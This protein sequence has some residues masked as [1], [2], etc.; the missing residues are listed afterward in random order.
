MGKVIAVFDGCGTEYDENTL[1]QKGLGG[2]ETWIIYIAESL[3]KIPDTHVF[4]YC[5]CDYHPHYKY[6]NIEF[7]PHQYFI[8][9][10]LNYDAII[11]SRALSAGL[12]DKLKQSKCCDNIYL[13]GHDVSI[14]YLNENN[15]LEV[16]TYNHFLKDDFMKNNIKKIFVLSK[17]AKEYIISISNF[18][19]NMVELTHY[20]INDKLLNVNNIL[21]RDNNI[22]W[23]NC[24]ERNFNVL[25]EKIA[26]KIIEKYPDFKIYF[27]YYGDMENEYR[28]PWLYLLDKDYVVN[29]GTLSKEQLYNEMSKHKCSFYPLLFEETFCMSCIEQ[30]MCGTHLF[31]PLR[32]GPDTILEPYKYM[33]LD[34]NIQFETEEEINSTVDKIIYMFEHYNDEDNI[35]FRKSVQNYLINKFD[36]DKIAK[37]L[38]NKMNLNYEEI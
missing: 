15:E 5:N 21:Q 25:V 29:V 2:S 26:P 3:A 11:I 14:E 32:Y 1:R 31:M 10:N 37:D 13:I 19:E 23:S 35:K 17:W 8:Y 24:I 18:P 9:S 38:Y 16:L 6:P 20:G 36:W 33:F 30:I 4:V 27:S 22:F 12:L 34:N 28:K 7:R